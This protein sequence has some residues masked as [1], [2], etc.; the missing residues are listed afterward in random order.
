MRSRDGFSKF[1]AISPVI[2]LLF[3]GAFP[4]E[5]TVDTVLIT[6]LSIPGTVRLPVLLFFLMIL[7]FFFI[8]HSN[9]LHSFHYICPSPKK[10]ISF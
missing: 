9:F 7:L 10:R 3:E 2:P 5:F 1:D 8:I 4:K 6:L